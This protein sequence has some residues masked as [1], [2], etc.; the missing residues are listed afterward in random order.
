MDHKVEIDVQNILD[1]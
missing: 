1:I